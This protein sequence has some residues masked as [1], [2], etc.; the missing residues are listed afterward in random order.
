MENKLYSVQNN[1]ILLIRLVICNR[2]SLFL[3]LIV[4]ITFVFP[5]TYILSSIEVTDHWS[6]VFPM[7][8]ITSRLFC[9][10]KL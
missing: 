10:N 8:E 4:K 2:I 3:N 5:G 9:K 1:S 6:L 7:F